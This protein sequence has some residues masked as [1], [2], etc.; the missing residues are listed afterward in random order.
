VGVGASGARSQHQPL[1]IRYLDVVVLLLATGP[2]LSLGVPAMGYL[3]GAIAWIAQRLLAEADS[4]WLVRG[5]APRTQ[6]GLSLAEAFGRIWLLVGAIVAAGVI[7]GRADGLTA[8]LVIFA[9]YSVAF[10]VKLI[11]RPPQPKVGQPGVGR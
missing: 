4:R 11:M 9:S 3:T 1:L 7:G 10:A 8:A 5:R 2:A 6:L